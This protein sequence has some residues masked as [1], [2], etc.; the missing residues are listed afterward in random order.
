MYMD[1]P[2]SLRWIEE[3]TDVPMMS[4]KEADPDAYNNRYVGYDYELA[5]SSTVAVG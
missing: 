1:A 2:H 5:L 3:N 4:V